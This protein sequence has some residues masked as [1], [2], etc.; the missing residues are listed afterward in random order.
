MAPLPGRGQTAPR[1][2]Q[3]PRGRQALICKCPVRPRG[4]DRGGA[5]PARLGRHASELAR[6]RALGRIPTAAQAPPPPVFP[7]PARRGVPGAQTAGDRMEAAS[8]AGPAAPQPRAPG[9]AGGLGS[10]LRGLKG[11]LFTW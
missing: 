9:A 2:P 8:P 4:P 5:Q 3:L 10:L 11:Q 7:A 1:D 6:A